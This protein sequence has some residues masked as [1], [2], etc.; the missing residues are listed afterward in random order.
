MATAT[1]K[2]G[3]GNHD[4]LCARCVS[5]PAEPFYSHNK[6]TAGYQ[7]SQYG[8]TMP[9]EVI[10]GSEA[11]GEL[12]CSAEA[13]CRLCRLFQ[14]V[15]QLSWLYPEEQLRTLPKTLRGW[16]YAGEIFSRVI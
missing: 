11:F 2:T 4:E 15:L 8:P 14:N 12:K 3:A 5:I 10:T 6:P 9:H 7:D 1:S 13:G 16:V